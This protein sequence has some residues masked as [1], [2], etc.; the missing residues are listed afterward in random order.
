MMTQKVLK[1]TVIID[2]VA[3][4]VS[5]LSGALKP[6]APISRIWGCLVEQEHFVR[7]ISNLRDEAPFCLGTELAVECS[8]VLPLDEVETGLADSRT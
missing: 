2:I 6:A 4:F 1:L 3:M 7:I 5:V 8:G